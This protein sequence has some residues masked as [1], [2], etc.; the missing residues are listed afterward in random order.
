MNEARQAELMI[1]CEESF[2]THISEAIAESAVE[3]ALCRVLTACICIYSNL[4]RPC[5]VAKDLA[6]DTQTGHDVYIGGIAS[7][8][9]IVVVFT[10][11]EYVKPA[12]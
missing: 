5:E 1:C 7:C 9:C 12:S 4:L 10:R 11:P 2:S 8:N 6:A 3:T